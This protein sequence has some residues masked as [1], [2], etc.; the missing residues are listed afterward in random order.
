M[1]I[2][3]DKHSPRTLFHC[4]Y[5]HFGLLN[6]LTVIGLTEITLKQQC[7]ANKAKLIS[8]YFLTL[9]L[10]GLL[11]KYVVTSKYYLLTLLLFHKKLLLD[12]QIPS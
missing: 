3:I 2:N 5:F 1:S 8:I 6:L 11:K 4:F 7:F 10:E 12:N 9:C